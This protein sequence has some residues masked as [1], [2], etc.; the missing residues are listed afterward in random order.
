MAAALNEQPSSIEKI[1]AEQLKESRPEAVPVSPEQKEAERK[2]IQ[3][4]EKIEP[5]IPQ[6]QMPSI[7]KKTLE[8]TKEK[9]AA[10]K[11]IETILSEGLEDIFQ[12]LPDDLK[13]EFKIK[14]EE[15]ASKIEVLIN[16]TKVVVHK[17]VDLIKSWLSIIPGVNK[18]FLE[19]EIKI[20]TGKILNLAEKNKKV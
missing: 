12:N 18:S 5:G 7:S 11:E 14:G 1:G 8:R 9:S 10:L 13:Q 20:K 4:G 17:I 3:P 16:Q 2:I 15:T 6:T 19:K